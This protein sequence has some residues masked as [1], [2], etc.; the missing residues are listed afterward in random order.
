[1][2]RERE[3]KRGKREE[4]KEEEVG[5]DKQTREHE[6]NRKSCLCSWFFILPSLPIG[7][8]SLD[9]CISLLGCLLPQLYCIFLFEKQKCNVVN[10]RMLFLEL[11]ELLKVKV[12][13]NEYL[14]IPYFPSKFCSSQPLSHS[15]TLTSA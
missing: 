3:L 6:A 4:E 1:M 12:F 13:T 7:T 10:F 9:D 11:H 14:P 5:R 15:G 2:W 8:S